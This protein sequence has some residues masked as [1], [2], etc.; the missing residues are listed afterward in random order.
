MRSWVAIQQAGCDVNAPN[1][2]VS[3][4]KGS[5]ADQS[6]VPAPPSISLPKGGGA[7]RGI[8]EKFAANPVTGTG[9]MSV[10]I[11]TS[12]GRSGFGPQLALSYDSG[13][14][15]GPFGFGW[16]LSLP[17]ITRKTDKGLPQYQDAEESDVF[18]LSG[19]EDLVPV[20]KTDPTTGDFVKDAKGNFVYDESP[21]DGYL[22]RRYRPRI[23]GLFA[24]IERWR[25]Q[26]GGDVHW[27]S[28]SKDNITTWYGKTEE[29]RLANPADASQI[30]SWLICQSYDDKGNAI[31]Y[32][33]QPEDS[34]RIFEDEQ[35]QLVAL[36]HERNR[37]DVT[38]SANRYLKRIKYG[39]REPN[40][41][42]STW[43][44]TDPAQLPNETW[45]FEVVFDYGDGH[46]ELL[47]QPTDDPQLASASVSPTAL[48]PVRQDPFS[49]YR[50]GFE[51]RTYRLCYR[52][53]MFHHFLDELG[54]PDYLVRSTEFTYNQSPIASF[55]TGVTQSGYVRQPNGNYLKKS[56]PP[57][58]FEYSKAVIHDE[59]E[60]VDPESLENL[61]VGADGLQYQW[62]D[63]DGEG[64]QGILSEQQAGWYYKRNRSPISTVKENGKEKVVARFEPLTE[65]ATE[66]SIAVGAGAR[67]EFLDLAGDG[68][69]DLVRF[70]KPVSGFFERTEDER[71]ES[72]VPFQSAPNLRW[73]DANL[74][75]VDLTGDGHTDILITEDDTF[76]WHPSLG[77][78]GFGPA[79]RASQ[80]LDEEKGPRLVFSDGTESFYLAD[81][82]GDGLSDL[83]RIRNGEVCYWPNLGYG[84][85][86]AKIAMDNAPWFD[87]P[88]Q[89]D[90]KRIRLADIDG[91]GT[92]D[93]IYLESHRVAIYRNECG[94]S[95][96]QAEYLTS[97]PPVD[98]LSSVTAVDLLGNGTACLVWSSPLPGNAR[99]PMRYIDLMSGQ[100]PHLLIKTINN[101]G[102]ET[103]VQYA[104][105]TKF[106][107]ID[108]RD[109]KPWITR[110]PFPVHVVERVET[111]DL[112]SRN[113]FVTRYAYH[114]GFYDG[115]ERE[116]RGFGMVEQFD[117]EELGALTDSGD[118]PN[119]TNIDAAS[120]VP[121]VLTKTW[122][123][124]GAYIE[125]GLISRHFEE[126]YYHEGDESE[127][128]SGLTDKQLEAM[129]LPDTKVPAT[130]KRQDGSS[131]PWDLT[132]EET[133][134]AC[135][136]LKGAVLR[137]EIFALDGT[138]D[139]DRPYSATE[140]N[141]TI[142]LLQPQGDDKHA[143]F[144][145]HARESIDFHYERKLIEVSG[146]KIADPRVTHAMTL[147]VDSYGN[148]LK[149]VATGYG[150]RP[151]LS[152]LHGDDKNKQEQIHVTYTENEVTNPIDEA[153]DYRTPLPCEACTYELIELPKLSPDSNQ[154]KITNL[155]RFDEMLAKAA[156]ASDG[157][158][159]LPYED[160]DGSG[161][162][163]NHPYRRLIEHVRTLYRRDNLTGLLSPGVLQSLALPGESYKLAF[164]PGLLAQVFQRN[165][166][167]LVPNP[168][169]VLGGPA[170]DHGGYVDL[171]GDHNWW[172]PSGKVFFHVNAD[173]ANP[174]V[175]A[176][177]ELAEARAHF[178]L[179]RKF[180]DPFSQ[181]ATLVY[182]IHD[183]TMVKTQDGLGNRVTAKNDY[184][185]LQPQQMTDPNGNR[186]EVAFDALGM[187]VAN[188]VKG[189]DG[190]NLGDLLEDFD[191]DPSLTALQTFFGDPCG[192]AA[193]LLGKTTTR[194]VYDL[195]RYQ[196]SGEP[197]FAATLVRETH[198]FDSSG[199][200]TKIQI[201]LSYSD[202]FGREIQK[203]I[204]AEPGPVPKRDVNGKIIVGAD[205]QPVM[206]PDDVS[207]RWVGSGWTVF[208]NKGKPVRQY[209]PFFTDTHRF[210][211]DVKIGVSPVLFYDPV[212]RVVTTLHPN[213][214][215]QKVV[216]NPWQ[217]MTY[218]V[219]DTVALD[220]KTDDDVKEFFTRL[221]DDDY[222]PTWHALRTDPTYAAAFAARYPDAVERAKETQAAEK[223]EVHAGTPSVAHADSLGQMFLTITYNKF[224]RN[225][226]ML[227]EKYFT[228]AV[229]DIEGN[230][231]QVIDANDRIVMRYD[232]DMLGNRIHQTSMEAGERWMLNDVVGKPIRSWDSRG[233]TRRMT[234]DR[235][236]RLRGL[237]VT[238]DGVERFAERTVYGESQGAAGNHRTRVFK[239]FDAA[240]VVTSEEYDFKGNLLQ[241]KR[242]LLPDYKAAVDWQQNPNAN[243]GTFTS[244]SEYDAL[245]RPLTV[246][247]P[248]GSVCRPAFNEANLLEKVEVNLPG[249]AQATPFVTDIDYNAKGQ[250]QLIAYG[251]GAETVFDHDPLTFRL[252][253]IKTTRP[254]GLNGLASKLFNDP[255]VV[256]DL[257]YTYDPA[258][259]I[260]CIADTSLARLSS[261]GPADNEPFEYIY[262]AIYRLIEATGREHIGQT[263]HDFNPQNRR[264]YDFA[265]LAHF[266]AHPNDLQA[267]RRYTERY[268]YDEV[269]NFQFTRH[270]AHGDS[271]TRIYEYNEA[272]LIEPTKQNNRLTRTTVGN[273]IERY[274]YTDSHGNDVHGCMTTINSMKVAWDF[275]DQLQA[276]SRQ[277]VNSGTPETTYYVYDAGGERVR[278]VTERQNGTRKN[279]RIYL[280]GFEIYREYD[281]SG[282]SVT[283]ERETLHTMDEKQRIALVE[284]KTI[285]GQSTIS[286]P[287]PL[288]RY[289]FGNH[290]GSVS[291]ELDDA[292]E[293]ISYE[294]YYPYGS[295]S[296]QAGRSA[297]EVSLKRYRYTGKERDEETGFAYHGARYYA[298]WLGRW[299]S[300]DPAEMIDGPNLYL[301]A[302]SSPIRFT[303]PS[304]S[305]SKHPEMVKPSRD[306]TVRN[307]PEKM[308]LENANAQSN[309]R[310]AI[311]ATLESEFGKGS[312]EANR[313]AFEQK[314]DR[315]G[316]GPQ[317][318][319]KRLNLNSKLGYARSISNRIIAR[320]YRAEA[321][322]PSWHYSA[323]QKTKMRT[324][325]QAPDPLQQ[326]EHLNDL[327]QNPKGAIGE[328]VYFTEGGRKGGIPK[329]SPHGQKNWGEPG[330][331]L[332]DFQE[333]N[334]ASPKTSSTAQEPAAEPMVEVTPK[335]VPEVA[336]KVV[337][338]VMPEVTPSTPGPG[339]RAPG[340]VRGGASAV[341]AI[342]AVPLSKKIARELGAS[343]ETEEEV[344]FWSSVGSGALMGAAAGAPE[345]GIGALPGAIIGG[346]I[347]A[348]AYG[349]SPRPFRDPCPPGSGMYG[350][351][352]FGNPCGL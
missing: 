185:V 154:P 33:Y 159:D 115:V 151:G 184:R 239:V 317:Q 199:A 269:G 334:A 343:A 293:L 171:E 155:F 9:S 127:G 219:N 305:D 114:H 109:G 6:S 73:N 58:S 347:G 212:E 180:A 14:G 24:R 55:I 23:E 16:S 182:D 62:L 300:C 122:F 41:D 328:D 163:A 166:Q 125:G 31:T 126:E 238:E 217:Q 200:Q 3:G 257:Y 336:P 196:R 175:T 279:E 283:L 323:D 143:V 21:R 249:A 141:Y 302:R 312:P 242:E 284:T 69:L 332:R 210:E 329:D 218:D 81:L 183:L 85:F 259:N 191:P 105:S 43:E 101:L 246:I 314:I 25:S 113:R 164:T 208:N 173:I 51:V 8:G 149:S 71:W 15:N 142:E 253:K 13:A 311:D 258:G 42:A 63:L 222:V 157:N 116:F 11:A 260:T 110:L 261:T 30:F 207:P 60:T 174:T 100:K 195:H 107:L 335:V 351:Q 26:S 295:T 223:T 331:R 12:P 188:A 290:V 224:E 144:F 19:A 56:L 333:R 352:T 74:K 230:Q 296:Y 72:F 78:E 50:A 342:V 255:A 344:G 86:G 39:S 322:R 287:S 250:R 64:L 118:F 341:V 178:F 286:S 268:E 90:Q 337:P 120:Y 228:R 266:I 104:P 40:R 145:T 307:N 38:R 170:A 28:I 91:S 324:K 87:Q 80:S 82:S 236:R 48:W 339:G 306:Y 70:E 187:V 233:F 131:I 27:R 274:T 197:P 135:R 84:R 152:P 247:T 99:R 304:G 49:S 214:S 57:L 20:F 77:E 220:P 66:P 277:V 169:A 138:D 291:L 232:Y 280:G 201:G 112:I 226:V 95:W 94:N 338:E 140:Q 18:I 2:T 47:S 153:D 7:I 321:A 32:E 275:K 281:S 137:R 46:Y 67:H 198:F 96:S 192:Q 35:G 310:A 346:I 134:E 156:Q 345:G 161:A 298:P 245:N 4:A 216:F 244:R 303:D 294:E 146:K 288:F 92:T 252:V 234:Y 189:K 160:I 229:F 309:W 326:V 165:G 54:A 318:I 121:T 123:H 52:V 273:H 251:N 297:A 139:E 221:P 119:A 5:A 206:T 205:G 267:M 340:V 97:F 147:D 29:S 132:A 215:W 172:I 36:A 89:F 241:S 301:F 240:G 111:R 177:L 203:K 181:S 270:I 68:S 237:F 262:D 65:V 34:E 124:T 202:G 45:M 98:D 179:P 168:T 17:S 190:Q 256:Q 59:I 186:S 320:F 209:E 265:G 194:I 167:A 349:F 133:Q 348:F 22:V 108:K 272:S 235:L 150:R 79:E 103:V 330:R 88:D 129:L 316:D 83:A 44:A 308:F 243:A 148:V 299:M 130:L 128:L 76:V 93:I 319:N 282:T 327:A 248:D 204:Q 10:P 254:P 313:A 193:S 350:G 285:D 315:L 37:D 1:Q 263:A 264:D 176:P 325:G 276:T 213:H 278:K 225:S 75:F 231:R 53:L 227:E 289:Q 292:G 117:T 61:P 271:W 102:A 106:Y 136:P 158:H 211:F 162:A